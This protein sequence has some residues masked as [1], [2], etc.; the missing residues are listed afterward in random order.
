MTHDKWNESHQHTVI[1]AKIKSTVSLK[2]ASGP[3]CADNGEAQMLLDRHCAAFNK[4]SD[5]FGN[6][7]KYVTLKPMP[8]F[9]SKTATGASRN[10]ARTNL[11]S[12]LQSLQGT[13]KPLCK[14]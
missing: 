7:A 1:H 2:Q 12:E 4:M 6:V 13:Q 5:G 14:R 10:S 3:V 8:S 11:E 9:D